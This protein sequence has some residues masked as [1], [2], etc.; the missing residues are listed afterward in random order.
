MRRLTERRAKL[1]RE[2]RFADAGFADNECELAH[3]FASQLPASAQQREL[4][5]APDEGGEKART[6]ASPAAR[7]HDPKSVAGSGAPSRRCAPRSSA[8]NRPDT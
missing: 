1:L 7:P 3:A 6:S 2:A 8:T 5:L 4:L